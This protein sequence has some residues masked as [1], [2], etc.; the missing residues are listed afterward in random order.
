MK[1]LDWTSGWKTYA[2]VAV[3][4]GTGVAQYYGYHIPT[5]V[6]IILGFAG[7]GTARLAISKQ[8]AK[9]AED[10]A[11][12]VSQVLAQVTVPPTVTVTA[13]DG[14]STT[15][16]PTPVTQVTETTVTEKPA[17]VDDPFFNKGGA[18]K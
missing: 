7:L 9:T 15:V 2:T 12:L 13:K 3:G 11:V 1:F 10:V 5:W 6:D 16:S 8:S 17:P 18:R 4:I 14:S